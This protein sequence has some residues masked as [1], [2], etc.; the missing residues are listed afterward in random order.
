MPT[1]LAIRTWWGQSRLWKNGVLIHPSCESSNGGPLGVCRPRHG[2]CGGFGSQPLTHMHSHFLLPAILMNTFFPHGLHDGCRWRHA[3]FA[4]HRFQLG[5]II[6][7]ILFGFIVLIHTHMPPG[8]KTGE[9][10]RRSPLMVH[11][12]VLVSPAPLR[13]LTTISLKAAWFPG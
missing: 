13:A 7:L 11:R 8:L 10:T 12:M 2:L 6:T 1:G 3:M 9:S 4:R 5:G